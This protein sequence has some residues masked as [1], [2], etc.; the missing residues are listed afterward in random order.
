MKNRIAILLLL[1]IGC[2]TV[3]T[4]AFLLIRKSAIRQTVKRR[5]LAGVERNELV[6]LTFALKDLD[7]LLEWE[8][9]REFAYQGVMYDLIESETRGDSIMYW[10]IQ[11]RAET[12]IN[13][14]LDNL[15]AKSAS[16]DPFS[17]TCLSQYIYYLKHIFFYQDQP[18]P[19]A[20]FDREAVRHHFLR[21]EY[22]IQISPP[23]PPPEVANPT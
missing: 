21:N 13:R 23:T 15:T 4:R 9:S 20:S 1:V 18:K 5:I 14:H 11:D 16:S 8:H 17:K 22:A 7:A 6:Q 19:I 3:G 12:E 10:C 2:P